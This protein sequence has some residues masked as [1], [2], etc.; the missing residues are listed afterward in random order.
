MSPP[1]TGQDETS[2]GRC[3]GAGWLRPAR[4]PARRRRCRGSRCWP[5]GRVG[6][7]GSGAPRT[8]S[9]APS[10]T[11]KCCS[12]TPQLSI[13]SRRAGSMRCNCRFGS[14]Y[15]CTL[16]S[17]TRQRQGCNCAPTAPGPRVPARPPRS[18]RRAVPAHP[19]VHPP[20]HPTRC[21]TPVV[22]STV[23][24]ER[25]VAQSPKGLDPGPLVPC[26]PAAAPRSAA[27][28]M[29]VGWQAAQR[30]SRRRCA[31]GGC[32][33]PARCAAHHWSSTAPPRP[34]GPVRP[35]CWWRCWRAGCAAPTCTSRRAICRC[36]GRGDPGHEVVGEV[37]AFGAEVDGF[38]VGTGSASPGCGTPAGARTAGAAP[39]TCAR[40]RATPAGTPTGIRR[41]RHRASGFRAPAA[42]RLFRQ[43]TGAATVRGHHRLP[44]TA[45]RRVA[46][47]RA[48]GPL[49][50]RR[51]RP[52]HRAGRHR[53][54]RGGA[55]DDPRGRARELALALGASSAQ[56]AADPPPVKLDAAILFAPVGDLVPPARRPSTAAAPWRSPASTCPTSRR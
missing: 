22:T 14:A 37:V 36:T 8:A 39:R 25:P 41:L 9:P 46:A 56:G 51:Q 11:V 19:H 3:A 31:R 54:G 53:S 13:R 26:R 15:R 52:H 1:G 7:L 48:A 16:S 30:A 5:G 21:R 40:I 33:G 44:V 38:A 50:L 23:T 43:R 10:A 34:R 4:C 28:A 27:G 47:R 49:R 18:P 17:P 42:G 32:A 45:A 12:A 35:I 2:A 55:R 29:M 24:P 6:R 20:V